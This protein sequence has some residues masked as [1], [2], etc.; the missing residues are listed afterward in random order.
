M[1]T[2][3][4]PRCRGFMV[5]DA[6]GTW[7]CLLCSRTAEVG[8]EGNLVVR[9][10]RVASAPPGRG[11]APTREAVKRLKYLEPDLSLAEIARRIGV[12]RQRVAVIAKEEATN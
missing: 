11:L 8:P 9:Y 2:L 6:D 12:S 7:T 10:P 3:P 4:C 1:T 5:P